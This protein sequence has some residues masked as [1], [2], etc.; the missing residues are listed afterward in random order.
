M[1]VTLF[2]L[3]VKWEDRYWQSIDTNKYIKQI[4]IWKCAFIYLYIYIVVSQ[5]H[6]TNLKVE[7]KQHIKN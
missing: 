1:C 5:L 4:Y 2:M 3:A 7:W 6:S